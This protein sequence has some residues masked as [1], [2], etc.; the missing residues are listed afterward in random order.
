VDEATVPGAEYVGEVGMV[1]TFLTVQ[2]DDGVV[3]VVGE[4]DA[5]T[6]GQL[7]EVLSM[8]DRTVPTLVDLSAVTF[9]DSSGLRI[10]VYHHNARANDS[11][12]LKIVNPSQ[13]VR[14]LLE[15]TGLDALC[16]Q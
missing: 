9:M 3:R 11:C 12:R 13:T 16:I 2:Y 10:L 4:V 7:D 15:I 8:L 6:C 5:S 14:R 1:D